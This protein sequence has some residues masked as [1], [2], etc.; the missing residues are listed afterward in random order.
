MASPETIVRTYLSAIRDPQ[1]LRDD[2]AIE[3][4]E[5][6]LGDASDPIERLRLQQRLTE[7]QSP[8]LDAVEDQF[9]THAKAWADSAGITAK[10]FVAEGVPATTLRR[11]GF[12]VGRGGGRSRARSGS[13]SKRSGS[14][15]TTEEVIASL[16]KGSFTVGAVEELTGASTQVVRKAINAEVKAGNVTKVG[17]DPDHSGPGRAAI[18][19]RKG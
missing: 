19:Y 4:A 17:P 11:A 8:S 10:A 15:V 13:R 14:R 1:S 9:V 3:Q 2:E 12:D 5:K 6:D 7:L 16:P 18:L